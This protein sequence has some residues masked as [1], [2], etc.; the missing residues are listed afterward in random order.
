M[1]W[2]GMGWDGMGWYGMVWDRMVWYGMVWYGATGGAVTP[3][4]HSEAAAA[5]VTGRIARR[6]PI[7]ARDEDRDG[8]KLFAAPIKVW[9]GWGSLLTVKRLDPRPR[10]TIS[11]ATSNETHPPHT[12]THT[13]PTPNSPH[14]LFTPYIH[15]PMQPMH[16]HIHTPMQPMQIAI[17]DVCVCG[18]C[19]WGGVCVC[20]GV[21]VVWCLCAAV[22]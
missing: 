8:L 12:H 1:V 14:P 2:Y 17:T 3:S 15:T 21:W 7:K 10:P 22:V 20:V 4:R 18:V 5:R 9:Y 13:P 16:T 6:A 19:V 11:H